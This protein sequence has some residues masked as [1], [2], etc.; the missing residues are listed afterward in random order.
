MN[1]HTVKVI[2]NSHTVNFERLLMLGDVMES[3]LKVSSDMVPLK[4]MPLLS[5]SEDRLC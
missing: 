5:S 1:Q 2:F 3:L 4:T